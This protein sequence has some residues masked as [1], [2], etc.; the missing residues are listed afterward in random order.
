MACPPSPTI[1]VEGSSDFTAE[2]TKQDTPKVTMM[3]PFGSTSFAAEVSTQETTNVKQT[4]NSNITAEVADI[5]SPELIG[6][7][8]TPIIEMT[9]AKSATLSSSELSTQDDTKRLEVHY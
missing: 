1:M 4:S 5:T 3:Q 8:S 9:T 6:E 2:P 7:E